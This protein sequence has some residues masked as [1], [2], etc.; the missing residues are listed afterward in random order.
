MY[1]LILIHFLLF[2]SSFFLC[3]WFHS[4]IMMTLLL[5]EFTSVS[6]QFNLCL[7]F[8]F[9]DDTSEILVIFLLLVLSSVDLAII[10]SLLSRLA[11]SFS[12]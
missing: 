1:F 8:F 2:I 10:L 5:L 6:T 11:H 7:S 12:F 4:N 3:I 9:T